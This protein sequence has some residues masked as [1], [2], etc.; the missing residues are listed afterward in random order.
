MYRIFKKLR[1]SLWYVNFLRFKCHV[2]LRPER[3][4][5]FLSVSSCLLLSF[6][7]VWY[8]RLIHFSND[9]IIHLYQGSDILYEVTDLSNDFVVVVASCIRQIYL[10]VMGLASHFVFIHCFTVLSALSFLF[11]FLSPTFVVS[12]S[13]FHPFLLLLN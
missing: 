5:V 1:K 3:M 13:H 4:H 8:T 11:P 7:G 2:Y 12:F 6:L 10:G 9:V